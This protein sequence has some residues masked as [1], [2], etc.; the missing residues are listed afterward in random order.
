MAYTP[1]TSRSRTLTAVAQL[2]PRADRRFFATQWAGVDVCR[3]RDHPGGGGSALFRMRAGAVIQLHDHPRGEHT[4]IVSGQARFG[5][6][7]L[8]P[9]DVLWTSPGESH[10]V[11]A[12]TA[13]EFIGIAPPA[14]EGQPA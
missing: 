8:G 12:I 11:E 7:E 4:F 5:E 13:V 9:G 14:I 2:F 10:V 3:F 6:I 1:R